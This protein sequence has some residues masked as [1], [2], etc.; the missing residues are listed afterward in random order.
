MYS[1]SCVAHGVADGLAEPLLHVLQDPRP[2]QLLRHRASRDGSLPWR[3]TSRTGSGQ[4]APGGVQV[5]VEARRQPGEDGG[6]EVAAGHA[7]GE[8]DALQDGDRGVADHQ[9]GVRLLAGPQPAAGGA[10]A[11][12][13]VEGELPRLQLRDAHPARG[14]GVVLA[15][16]G[17]AP[18]SP[19]PCTSTSTTP[20]AVRS[21]VSTESARRCRSSA[22]TTRR[23]TTMDDVVVLPAGELGRVLQV[24]SPRRPPSRGRSPCGAR[25]RRARGT[26]PSGP[27]P[28]ARGPPGGC[29]PA[30]PRIWSTICVAL[31]RRTGSPH[32]GQWGVPGP[33]PEEAQVVVDLRH[34]PHRGAR[35]P[36]GRL[37]L[38]GDGRARAPRWRRRPASPSARGTAGRTRRATPRSAAGPRRRWCRRP[39][40]TSR[41]R[42]GP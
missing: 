21:A 13:R 35:V 33:G 7:P 32:S 29:P 3:S 2:P 37:L 34:R 5:E 41:S 26:R 40:T 12:G 10:G 36:P 42:S 15:R 18:T 38:D 6:A 27:A 17:G 4:L 11:V 28:A 20:S 23:S 19:S 16:R 1:S 24:A 31:C 30:R 22:R 39:A 25:P 9:L 8:D 14:A